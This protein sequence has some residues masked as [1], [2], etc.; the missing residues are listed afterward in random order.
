M[1]LVK[2]TMLAATAAVAVMAFIDVSTAFATPPWIA[3]CLKQ[4][5]LS[6]AKGNLVKHPL[7]GRIAVTAGVNTFASNFKIE[8]TKASGESSLVESQQNGNAKRVYETLGIVECTGG[9]K[10]V[11]V[12]IPQTVELNMETEATESWRAKSNNL[13]VKFS[14]CTFGVECKFEANLNLRIQMN[15]E[16][17]FT[18][19]EGTIFKL[20]EGSKF[21]CGETGK[22]ETGRTK[23]SWV[24]DDAAKTT[25]KSIWPSLIGKELIVVP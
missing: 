12:F 16:G 7:L 25:F 2:L 18:E 23:Y 8:C 10:K 24:L 4:E 22:W 6:C 17:A 21:L 20:I 5:L 1:K 3:V 11:Q 13:K 14:E 9:C 15:E 19:P